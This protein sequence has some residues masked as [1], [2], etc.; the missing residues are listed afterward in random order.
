M[1]DKSKTLSV[2]QAID[3]EWVEIVRAFKVKLDTDQAIE[4]KQGFMHAIKRSMVDDM[5]KNF[6]RRVQNLCAQFD[7]EKV[8]TTIESFCRLTTECLNE[9][10]DYDNKKFL[11]DLINQLYF[12]VQSS[13]DDPSL[14][15]NDTEQLNR[16]NFVLQA[17]L[18]SQILSIT[19]DSNFA[20]V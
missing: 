8:L 10:S 3:P 9:C 17:S 1:G 7:L 2:M 12:R 18:E 20:V 4:I 14:D 6:N 19:D 13:A 16:R 11:R 15:S 5:V